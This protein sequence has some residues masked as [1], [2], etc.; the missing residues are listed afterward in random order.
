MQ[1]KAKHS[2]LKP[3]FQKGKEE[4]FVTYRE[5]NDHLPDHMDAVEDVQAL[6]TVSGDMGIEVL[7]HASEGDDLLLSPDALGEEAAEAAAVVLTS[8]VA[9]R[10]R[11]IGDPLSAYL[12]EMGT[13]DL[14]TKYQEVALAKQ[15]EAGLRQQTEAI[16]ACP[17]SI[18]EVLD[19]AGRVEAGALALS[20]MV[21]GMVVLDADDELASV[22]SERADTEPD[23]DLDGIRERFPRL[24]T[25]YDELI[26]EIRTQGVQSP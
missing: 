24:R 1:A 20:D 16:A 25:L 15:I 13:R 9:D 22:S 19:L 7:E 5:L 2:V 12:R 26:H 8:V 11:P 6:V 4:G 10:S 3:L 23:P 21:A 18:A 17:A 14:L